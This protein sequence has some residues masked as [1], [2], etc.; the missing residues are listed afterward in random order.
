MIPNSIC[1]KPRRIRG[2]ATRSGGE[3]AE[4]RVLQATEP[5][6]SKRIIPE[7]LI[8]K[9]HSDMEKI[10]YSFGGVRFLL[11]KNISRYFLRGGRVNGSNT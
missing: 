5:G 8:G 11:E 7:Y 6:S 10:V 9:S 4:G 2:T 1:R 3:V